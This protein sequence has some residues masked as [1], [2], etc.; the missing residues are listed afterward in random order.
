MELNNFDYKN[1]IHFVRPKCDLKHDSLSFFNCRPENRF[2][3]H[4]TD[5]RYKR[6]TDSNGAKCV[7]VITK[8][9]SDSKFIELQL[10]LDIP[11]G[12]FMDSVFQASITINRN[13]EFLREAHDS[14][15]DSI[16]SHFLE[17][18]VISQP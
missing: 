7:Y 9:V 18:S 16:F 15:L 8:R 13:D 12:G 3:I 11:T 4:F 2:Y 10:F 5:E 1:A 6:K 17:L 14:W